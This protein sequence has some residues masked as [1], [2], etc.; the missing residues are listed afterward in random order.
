MEDPF[1][2]RDASL[3]ELTDDP[4]SDQG[5]NYE[6]LWT[7]TGGEKVT[8]PE[9][10]PHY[11]DWDGLKEWTEIELH[12]HG[13]VPVVLWTPNP[14]TSAKWELIEAVPTD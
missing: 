7:T 2:V 11:D 9:P 13:Y 1:D 8:R 3:C 5:H 4:Q 12:A 6:L 10:I 14:S